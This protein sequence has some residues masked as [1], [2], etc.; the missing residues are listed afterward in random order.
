[1]GIL[2]DLRQVPIFHLSD[3]VYAI[4][5]KTLNNTIYFFALVM[6]QDGKSYFKSVTREF[7]KES[8]NKAFVREL[9]V[10]T[11]Q[12]LNKWCYFTEKID[13]R[14]KNVPGKVVNNILEFSTCKSDEEA[15]DLLSK[16]KMI[17]LYE[18]SFPSTAKQINNLK[19]VFG[20]IPKDSKE[21]QEN[22]EWYIYPSG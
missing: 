1:M 8:L 18:H 4:Q 22:F 19:I 15:L 3:T 16:Q 14:K 5:K 13:K 20:E 6:E 17:P 11:R 2:L 9:S 10:R 21:L 7:L 12:H